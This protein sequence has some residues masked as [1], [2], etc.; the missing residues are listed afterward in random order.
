MTGHRPFSELR[1]HIPGLTSDSVAIFSG[2]LDSTTLVYDMLDKG[3]TPHLVSFNY[4]Q[5]HKRELEFAAA[6]GV[7]LGLRHDIIDLTMLTHLISNSALTSQN[8]FMLEGSN[9][10]GIEVPE[11]GRAH[12]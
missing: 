1:P 11:I 7:K 3:Y 8:S 10:H 12:V 6:T 4:G 9:V 2:G 5:R